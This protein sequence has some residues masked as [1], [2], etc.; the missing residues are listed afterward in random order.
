MWIR[1]AR[2]CLAALLLAGCGGAPVEGDE[3]LRER[4][5]PCDPFVEEREV[6]I[7]PEPAPVCGD[8]RATR[9]R[10]SC[11]QRC[12]HG[13]G[14][15]SCGEPECQYAEERC[16]GADL[17]AWS[18]A[19]NG[20][21]GGSI[22]CTDACEIDWDGCVECVERPG[23]RCA[24]VRAD[25]GPEVVLVPIGDRVAL[26]TWNGETGE[27]SAGL[28]DRSLELTRF[29]SL[30]RDVQ[31]AS[32]WGERVAV[33][34]RTGELRAIDPR[35]GRSVTLARGLATG[36]SVALPEVGGTGIAVLGGW[37]SGHERRIDLFEADGS[38]M[39]LSRAAYF[40]SGSVA[41]MIAPVRRAAP[42]AEVPEGLQEGDQIVGLGLGPPTFW[43]RR[44]EQLHAL[45][46]RDRYDWPGGAVVMEPRD[47]GRVHAA[48]LEGEP[49]LTDVRPAD[50]WLETPGL[51]RVL[52][53]GPDNIE[54]FGGRLVA[55]TRHRPGEV[56]LYLI[57]GG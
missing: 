15:E 56:G 43:V 36:R 30:A 5:M 45:G 1:L 42:A 24:T 33:L 39:S 16:D 31:W 50:V 34:T 47:G 26:V 12:S 14:E 28:V 53:D 22:R 46:T 6:A 20:F 37:E 10:T 52:V 17:G 29:R 35:T 49:E 8:G 54:A 7:V 18:C 55:H 27:L 38:P 13:C 25:A 48:R 11:I 44:G 23:L 21:P 3:A 51:V 2:S 9:A 4:R 19:D 41:M 57:E 32:A 40:R